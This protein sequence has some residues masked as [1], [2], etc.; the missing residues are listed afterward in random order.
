MSTK[1]TR[2]DARPT[3]T[4]PTRRHRRVLPRPPIHR[5][6]RRIRPDSG[7]TRRVAARS[8]PNRLPLT[9]AYIGDADEL[10]E[11]AARE[12]AERRVPQR[13]AH[14]FRLRVNRRGLGGM[15]RAAMRVEP[16]DMR[17]VLCTGGP[18][19]EIRAEADGS[20]HR[21]Q[22]AGMSSSPWSGCPFPTTG[23]TR[24]RDPASS[25]VMG[26]N[27]RRAGVVR[28]VC[29]PTTTSSPRRKGQQ[30]RPSS[31]RD[32]PGTDEAETQGGLD[33]DARD[34]EA[35]EDPALPEPRRAPADSVSGSLPPALDSL[36]AEAAADGYRL[37][38]WAY[39]DVGRASAILRKE[40]A[41]VARK[42]SLISG[43]T[44]ALDPASVAPALR[45][46]PEE[47][48]NPKEGHHGPEEREGEDPAQAGPPEDRHAA[49]RHAH[50][51]PEDAQRAPD[52]RHPPGGD[53][54]THPS[55]RIHN[56][57]TPA[58]FQVEIP[59]G[60]VYDRGASRIARQNEAPDHHA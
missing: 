8:M 3:G 25:E 1:E 56:P 2:D 43:E 42:V 20:N 5:G 32:R 59:P 54:V 24:T 41:K 12:R 23:R 21:A 29:S 36:L 45:S 52:C 40:R 4:R 28:Q 33:H 51:P 17:I 58:S 7:R 49:P 13:L 38:P 19:V 9:V 50:R 39:I 26:E 48:R 31:R 46:E 14:G 47:P 55:F 15:L 53:V 44:E 35:A 57:T 60:D 37:P 11:R 16:A 27:L 10:R 18:H 34:T 22:G 6:K 30:P